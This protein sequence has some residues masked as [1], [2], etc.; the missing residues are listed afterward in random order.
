[1]LSDASQLVAPRTPGRKLVEAWHDPAYLNKL[2]SSPLK[3]AQVTE[4]APLALLPMCILKVGAAAA[5]V[6]GRA[7]LSAADGATLAVGS[8]R[9]LRGRSV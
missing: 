7:P 9:R 2:Y 8:R 1:V 6:R 5:P 4:L 3:V